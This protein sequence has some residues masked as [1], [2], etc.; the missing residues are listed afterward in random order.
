MSQELDATKQWES[1]LSIVLGAPEDMDRRAFFEPKWINFLGARTVDSEPAPNNAPNTFTLYRKVSGGTT[2]SYRSNYLAPSTP[3]SSNAPDKYFVIDGEVSWLIGGDGSPDQKYTKGFVDNTVKALASG[4]GGKM[5]NTASMED[6]ANTFLNLRNWLDTAIQRIHTEIGKVGNDDSGF[7]GTAAGAFL[8]TLENLR[9]ELKVL[10]ADLMKS[11]DWVVLL[12]DNAAAVR[13]FWDEIPKAWHRYEALDSPGKIVDGVLKQIRD[14]ADGLKSAPAAQG[15]D[16]WI[17][18]LSVGTTTKDYNLIDGPGFEALNNDMHDYWKTLVEDI[19]NTMKLQFQKLRDSFEKTALHMNEPRTFVP[20]TVATPPPPTQPGPNG[21]TNGDGN[22][23]ID[24]IVNAFNKGGG[25]GGGGGG[26]GGG[27]NFN[28]GGGGDG[29]GGN[30]GGNGPNAFSFGGG[31]GGGGGG[32]SGPG[33]GSSFGPGSNGNQNPAPD[34]LNALGGGG[35]GGGGSGGGSSFGQAGLGLGAAGAPG[36]RSRDGNAGAGSSPG[37]DDFDDFIDNPDGP[38]AGMSIGG[39]SGPGLPSSG[40]STVDVPSFG[41]AAGE[42]PSFGSGGGGGPGGG[43]TV[44][45]LGSGSSGGAG[46][47]GGGGGAGFGGASAGGPGG[48]STIGD[49]GGSAADTGPGFGSDGSSL[50]W[51][52]DRVPAGGGMHVGPLGVVPGDSGMDFGSQAYGGNGTWAAGGGG[53][54]GS[55]AGFGGGSG[56]GGGAGSAPVTAGGTPLGGLT[57]G[58]GALGGTSAAAMGASGS[59]GGA[60]MMPP[61]MPPGAAGNQ[62]KERER[63]TWLAEEEEVWGTDPDVSPAVVGR[64]EYADADH[65]ERA[66]WSPAPRQPTGPTGPARGGR[67]RGH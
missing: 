1:G 13:T 58:A 14:K 59:P 52:P 64:D 47:G 50:P 8:Q 6:A 28:G 32:N 33:G 41:S 9:D 17:F 60:P 11:Q 2:T 29:G 23:T 65:D 7:K 34:Q 27:A 36:P 21:D 44:G 16:K 55:G 61:M 20:K 31:G 35:G 53:G 15:L 12:N 10:Q 26:N 38:G 3:V 30:G 39:G 46:F 25:G 37:G 43:G 45:A 54:G 40:P 57:S 66:P 4:P 51:P 19:D 49:I 24:D 56:F 42:A 22:F 18:N 62:D 48:G 67:T 5:L 63:T